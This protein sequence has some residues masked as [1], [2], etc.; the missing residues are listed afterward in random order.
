MTVAEATSPAPTQ[1]LEGTKP[2]DDTAAVR[3]LAAEEPEAVLSARAQ[4]YSHE[5]RRALIDRIEAQ[6]QTITH[7]RQR[8]HDLETRQVVKPTEV[9]DDPAR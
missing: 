9:A 5:D 4:K 8:V 6:E 2:A 3:T 1:P 7:L